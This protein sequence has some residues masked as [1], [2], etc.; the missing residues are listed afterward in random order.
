MRVTYA[1]PGV[2]AVADV[3]PF[4]V[5]RDGRPEYL[6]TRLN[7]PQEH[8]GQ[9]LGSR[10]LATVLEAA[11]YEG[12]VLYVD[13]MPNGDH[14]R[15]LGGLDQETLVAFYERRGFVR[16]PDGVFWRRPPTS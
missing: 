14:A 4:S 6:L 16:R 11:D 2:R 1:L 8:R 7:V 12:A 9:G 3:E 5:E 10:L 15:G 13:P